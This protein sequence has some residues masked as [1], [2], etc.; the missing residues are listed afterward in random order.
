ML[1]YINKSVHLPK[2]VPLNGGLGMFGG[3]LGIRGVQGL[4]WDKRGENEGTLTGDSIYQ[5][6][7]CAPHY[8]RGGFSS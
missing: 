7:L 5:M 6:N 4:L 1:N 8:C 3:V 2:I